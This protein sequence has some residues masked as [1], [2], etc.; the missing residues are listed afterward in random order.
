[1]SDICFDLRY[2]STVNSDC[3]SA[4][5]EVGNCISGFAKV[6]QRMENELASFSTD[7]IKAVRAIQA[8]ILEVRD[9]IRDTEN[10]AL[11]AEGKRQKE[12]QPPQK[13]S[14]P[15]NA[16][17]EQKNAI[18]SSYHERVSRVDAENAEIRRQN[19]RIDEYLKRC[20]AA[21]QQLEEII[22][23][24]YEAEAL[25]KNE[26]ERTVACVH[27]F[28]GQA[29]GITAYNARI[30]SAMREFTYAFGEVYRAAEKLYL[31]E[32]S[33]IHSYSYVDRQFV[34]KNTHSHILTSGGG[35]FN[36]SGDESIA[37]KTEN[38][39]G[40]PEDAEILIRERSEEA[41]F[42]SISGAKKIK[43]PSA[44]LH[45]LGGKKFVA[46]M[47]GMG[48]TLITQADGSAIDSN[49]MLHWEM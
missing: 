34:I 17:P 5:C 48:Y 19:E 22:S 28:M 33:S 9:L 3:N 43:M 1:M 24:L 13:P 41:F 38:K 20:N 7:G 11:C 8:H 42:A 4:E 6:S 2:M 40:E 12:I 23:K 10:K 49:G 26:I 44:N 45:K 29:H 46:K 25:L 39:N 31:A 47:N 15:S 18:I 27:E 35:S 16:S 30:N 21:K 37:I 32:P 14:V 36:F